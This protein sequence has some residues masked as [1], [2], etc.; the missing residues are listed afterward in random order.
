LLDL[1]QAVVRIRHIRRRGARAPFSQIEEACRAFALTKATAP[2]RCSELRPPVS[3][4]AT[5][6][7]RSRDRRRALSPEA[8]T[9]RRSTGARPTSSRSSTPPCPGLLQAHRP[10]G[11]AGDG[12]ASG[13]AGDGNAS[14]QAAAAQ[15]ERA[16]ARVVLNCLSL[17]R[18]VALSGWVPKRENP[19]WVMKRA[20]SSM[21]TTM[22]CWLGKIFSMNNTQRDLFQIL[23]V[24]LIMGWKQPKNPRTQHAGREKKTG[25]RRQAAATPKHYYRAYVLRLLPL[26][27][28]SQRRSSS[29]C[30][31]SCRHTLKVRYFT[32]IPML[33]FEGK[34]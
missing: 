2:S 18:I 13:R 5:T 7:S 12:N 21:P 17:L 8:A 15:R 25:R 19:T 28:Q 16:T 23:V 10:S 33:C 29:S 26:Q 27:T 30:I 32:S 6:P 22:S 11:R 31:L 14:E 24:V 3:T 20:T 34:R 9:R 1:P 4:E